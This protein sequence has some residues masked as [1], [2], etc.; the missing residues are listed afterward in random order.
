MYIISKTV[1]DRRKHTA[2]P[3]SSQGSQ[4]SGPTEGIKQ[5]E[6]EQRKLL[7][8]DKSKSR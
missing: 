7:G 3:R 5:I 1:P 2:P 4:A 6:R 8:C